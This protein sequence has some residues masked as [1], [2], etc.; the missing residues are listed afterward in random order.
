MWRRAFI[1]TA[2]MVGGIGCAGKQDFRIVRAEC[3]D[4]LLRENAVV[5]EGHV[6]KS[7]H[8]A[9][10]V[11]YIF[12]VIPLADSMKNA[13]YDGV[14]AVDRVL[15]GSVEDKTIK[16][17]NY[18]ALTSEEN[19]A[20]ADGYGLHMNSVVRLG[21]DHHHGDRLTALAIVP[22]GNTPEFDEAIRQAALMRAQKAATRPISQ[23][24]KR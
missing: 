8:T 22:L 19:A 4:E 24:V 17:S 12:F 9:Q 18:R 7:V 10:P 1:L 21:Y 20:F 3:R 5:I 6:I 13:T 15:K 2:L 14:V 16:L 23:P 11:E